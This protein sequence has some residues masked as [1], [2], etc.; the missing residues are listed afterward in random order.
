M[1]GMT[2]SSQDTSNQIWQQ[3]QNIA[4]LAQG[5][6]RNTQVQT[7]VQKAR[8]E[9]VTPPELR[10]EGIYARQRLIPT[11]SGNSEKLDRSFFI[12]PGSFFSVGRVFKVF[13]AEPAG[14]N[15]TVATR[16]TFKNSFGEK[17]ALQSTLVCGH[18]RGR[19]SL[20]CPANRHVWWPG[21]C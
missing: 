9:L 4:G 11:Q 8:P 7:L 20:W 19:L 13:W 14:G 17:C 2:F 15:A 1:S 10:A 21:C 12:R 16:N 6:D 3:P 18:S 5:F